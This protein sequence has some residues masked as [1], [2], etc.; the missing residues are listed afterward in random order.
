MKKKRKKS[1]KY[2]YT[3]ENYLQ[4]LAELRMGDAH[5]EGV[6]IGYGTGRLINSIP[7]T[8]GLEAIPDDWL[9][10]IAYIKQLR[11]TV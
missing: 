9:D 6:Q 3:L 1:K 11:G 10:T 8:D 4:K 7:S 2:E 5:P